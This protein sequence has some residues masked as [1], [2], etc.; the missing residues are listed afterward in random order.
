MSAIL[1]AVNRRRTQQEVISFLRHKRTCQLS[2]SISRQVNLLVFLGNQGTAIKPV[3]TEIEK[4]TEQE[5][6]LLLPKSANLL[7]FL[8]SLKYQN[9]NSRAKKAAKPKFCLIKQNTNIQMSSQRGQ[10]QIVRAGVAGTRT[11]VT[12]N[13]IAGKE[14]VKAK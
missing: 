5:K 7:G 6:R 11:V 10:S 13:Y 3:S 2:K 8:Q 14:I 4:L 12:R 1:K 9:S